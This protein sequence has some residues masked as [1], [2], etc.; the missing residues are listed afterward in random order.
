[1]CPAI[2]NPARCDILAIIC[3]LHAENL[4]VVEIHCE[5]CVAYGQYIMSEATIRQWCRMF[6][7]GRTNEQMFMMKSEVFSC[8]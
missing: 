4:S 6:K 2:D 1:M 5:L 7:N 8:L 3:F